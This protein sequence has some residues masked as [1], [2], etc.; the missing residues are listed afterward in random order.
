MVSYMC[1]HKN[2]LIVHESPQTWV[3]H[4]PPKKNTKNNKLFFEK[5]LTT[6]I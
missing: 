2:V 6:K 3:Y 1:I 5:K 4:S